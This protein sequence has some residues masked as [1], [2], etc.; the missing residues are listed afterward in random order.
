MQTDQ[1]IEEAALVKEVFEAD[2]QSTSERRAVLELLLMSIK[3]AN[4]VA[5][6]AWAVTLFRDGF[7]LN[8]GQVDTA[9]DLGRLGD[10]VLKAHRQ[11]VELAARSPSGK[12]RAVTRFRK[13]HCE[14][15]VKY[16]TEFVGAHG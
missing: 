9:R 8:V 15:L 6:S 7:R 16:A 1:T 2:L 11:F 12:P 10:A 3:A 4:R 14:G 5:P 13:S